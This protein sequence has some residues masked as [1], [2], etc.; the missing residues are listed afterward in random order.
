MNI[1]VINDDGFQS[2]GIHALAEALSGVGDVY[3]C[4]PK[5][6]NSGGSQSLTLHGSITAEECDMPGTCGGLIVDGTPTD[7]TKMGIQYFGDRGIKFDLLFSGIN[8]GSNLGKDTL[9]SGTVGAAMEGALSNIRSVAVSIDSHSAVDFGP[10]CEI[11]VNVIDFVL[12]KTTPDTVLNINVPY[13]PKEEIRGVRVTRLGERYY[14]DRFVPDGEGGYVL[15]GTPKLFPDPEKVYDSTAISEGYI[16]ITPM[17][18]DYTDFS[19][20]ETLNASG[21]A[22]RR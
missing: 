22:S 2:G 4:A 13:I 6:Q 12:T 10:A 20:L 15:E 7:C 21:I 14:N 17:T 5:H 11:A 9:Y 16:S 8:K 19:M 3:V 1:L 18:F